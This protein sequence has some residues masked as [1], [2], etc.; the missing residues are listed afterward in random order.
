MSRSKENNDLSLVGLGLRRL[1]IGFLTSS[2]GQNLGAF[3]AGFS[4]VAAAACLGKAP[5]FLALIAQIP[6]LWY[7]L[8]LENFPIPRMRSGFRLTVL[9]LFSFGA[10]STDRNPRNPENPRTGGAATSWRTNPTN[11]FLL[12]WLFFKDTPDYVN[13]RI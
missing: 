7:I 10:I 13:I 3:S 8:D 6:R 5:P 2:A 11:E 9:G 1:A 12:L 4:G